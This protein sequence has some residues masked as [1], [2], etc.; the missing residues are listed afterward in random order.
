[1]EVIKKKQNAQIVIEDYRNNIQDMHTWF[2]A[3]SKRMEM[4]DKG[5]GLDCDQKLATISEIR[6]EFESQGSSK[7]TT[8]KQLASNVIDLVSNLDSQQV[9]EQVS[10]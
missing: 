1:M 9:E 2:D 6:D 4:L 10:F 3:L 5:S 7:L 8:V